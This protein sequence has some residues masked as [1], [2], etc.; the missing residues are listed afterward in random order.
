[1][2]WTCP[3]CRVPVQHSTDVPRTDR[4]YRCPVCGRAMT[5]DPISKTMRLA[6]P[7]KRR[8]NTG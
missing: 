7:D 4:V 6:L 1:M 3:V 2:P 8:D 5:F